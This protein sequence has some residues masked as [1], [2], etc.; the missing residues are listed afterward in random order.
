MYVRIND[1]TNIMKGACVQFITDK[2]YLISR[3]IYHDGF[4]N[5][6]T[7]KFIDILE[8]DFSTLEL[9]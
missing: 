1:K 5:T 7:L 6:R 3:V 9:F 8:K 2:Y 4:I